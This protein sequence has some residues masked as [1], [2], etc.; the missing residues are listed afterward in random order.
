ML[1]PQDHVG[2]LRGD[3]GQEQPARADSQHAVHRLAARSLT[4]QQVP[5]ASTAATVISE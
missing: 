1:R 3:A 2:G 4:S 5:A